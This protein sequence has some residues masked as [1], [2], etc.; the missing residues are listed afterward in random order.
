ME[1]RRIREI[2]ESVKSEKEKL[3]D[4]QYWLKFLQTSSYHYKHSFDDQIMINLQNPQF[5]A[6]SDARSWRS[7]SRE[8]QGHGVPTLHNGKIR[9]LFDI[10]QT[11]A[12]EGTPLPWVWEINDNQLNIDYSESVS[13]HLTEKYNLDSET[14]EEQLYDITLMRTAKYLNDDK[15]DLYK[16]VAESAAYSLLYRCCPGEAQPSPKNLTGLSKYPIEEIGQAVSE[17]SKS[18]FLEIESIVR[19]TRHNA[20]EEIRRNEHNETRENDRRS[21]TRSEPQDRGISSGYGN[22][23]GMDV[24]SGR[25]EFPVL[26]DLSEGSPYRSDIGSGKERISGDGSGIGKTIGGGKRDS[27]IHGSGVRHSTGRNERELLQDGIGV[28]ETDSGGTS[29][30]DPS[31]EVRNNAQ[32]LSSQSGSQGI[33]MAEKQ[34]ST[35]QTSDSRQSS[36]TRN[37]RYDS[38]KTQGEQSGIQRSGESGRLPENSTASEQF[39]ENSR[40]RNSDRTDI[41]IIGNTPYRYIPQKT[42]RKY[43]T[44]IAAKIADKLGESGIKFSGK[45]AGETTTITVSKADIERLEEIAHSFTA[46]KEKFAIGELKITQDDIEILR[47][48]EPRKSILNFTAEE[49]KLTE[50]WQQRFE[51]DIHEKSPY[52]RALNGDWRENDESKVTVIQVEDRNVDFKTVSDDIKTQVIQRGNVINND[53][54]WT[55]QVSRRGLEDSLTYA[56]RHNNESVYNMLYNI[57]DI[58]QNGTLLDSVISEKNNNNK[59]NNTAFMHKMYSVCKFNNEPY[60][61]K[62]A[63]EEFAV[64]S[65]TLKRLYN[66]QD[67]KIEPLRHAA[68]ADLNQLALSV[69]NGTEISIADLFKIVKASDKDFYINKRTDIEK[70]KFA[71]DELSKSVAENPMDRAIRLI[72]EY[73]EKE[74]GSPG[75]FSNMDHIELA[76]KPDEETGLAGIEAY[77]DLET[78][79]IVKE[80]DGR[81]VDEQLFN[82]L[83]HMNTVLKN[84][85]F[86]KLIELS[87]N[88]KSE[89]KT[90][91]F[92]NTEKKSPDVSE[93]SVG[94]VILYDG[95]RREVEQISENS[96][97]L[98]DLDAPDFGGILLGTSDVLA[99]NGWQQDMNEKGFEILSKAAPQITSKDH[100]YVPS[101]LSLFGEPVVYE[102]DAEEK[103]IYA[104]LMRGSGFQDGKFRIEKFCK[105]NHSIN[106]FAK[107]LKDEYGTGGRSGNEFYA[108]ENYDSKGIEIILNR[109]YDNEEGKKIHLKWKEVAE[110]ISELVSKGEYIAKADIDDHI[111]HAKYTLKHY[112]S[113]KYYNSDSESD[114]IHMERAKNILKEYGILSENNESNKVIPESEIT[115]TKPDNN[116]DLKNNIEESDEKNPEEN[117]KPDVPQKITVGDRFRHKITGNIS[118]V[119]SLTG[120]FPWITDECTVTRDSGAFSVTE[121][122]SYN[123][124]LNSDLYEYIDHADR[125]VEQAKT[126]MKSDMKIEN[127]KITGDFII[128][129]G[130]KSKFKA[131][132]KAIRTLKMIEKENRPATPEEQVIL[133]RYVGWG[134]LSAAFDSKNAQWSAEYSELKSLLTDEEYNAAR[135]SVLDSFYT[136]PFIIESIYSA[137][138]NMG[139]HGGSV[140]DPS[141]GTGNFLG[142]MPGSMS[143]NSRIY[144]VEKDSV[145]GRIAKFLYPDADIQITGFEKRDFSDNFFDVAVGNI[146]F[147]SFKISDRRYDKYNF[148]VHDYFIAKTLDKVRPGGVIAFITSSGTLDKANPSVRKYISQRAELLGAVRLPN[149]AFKSYAGTEVTSDIIFLRKREKMIDIA[150]DWVYTSKNP[151]GLTINNYFIENPEMILGKVVEGNKLYGKGT[152]VVPFENS[153]LK[154]ILNEAVKKIKGNYTAEKSVI[155]KPSGKKKDKFKPEILPAD[156]TVKNFSYAEIDGKIF[157]REN[158][159]MTEMPFTGKRYERVSGIAAISKCVREL[160]NMQLEGY[161]DEAIISKRTELNQLYDDFTKKNGLL[162]DK[163]NRDIFREDVSLPLVLSLEKVK[164]GKLIGKADIF[165]K[166]TLQPPVRITHADTAA[167]ALAVSISEK[168]GVDLDFMSE[169]MDGKEKSEIISDL[170]G[171]IFLNPETSAWETADAYLSGNI[172]NKL[173]AAKS[174]AESNP[175]FTENVSALEAAM[176]DRIEAGDITAKLGSPWID[177]KYIQEFMYELFE[178]P[179]FS[180]NLGIDNNYIGI[181]HNPATAKWNVMNKSLDKDNI[182]SNTAYGT[183]RKSGYS[184]FEDS[185]NMI[186]TTVYDPVYNPEKDKTEYVINHDETLLARQKQELIENAFREWIFKDPERREYL[187]EKYNVLYNSIRPREY[188]GSHL[189]FAGMNPEITLKKHQKDAVAH[190]LYGGNTL[191]AH[192]VGAGKTY[193]MIAAAMEGKR[194]GLH[195]KSLLAVPNHMTEQFANDFLTLYPNANILIAHEDDFKKENRQKLCAKIATGEFDAIIIGHSQL[196]KIPVSKER[197]EQFIQDQINELINDIAEMKE[198]NAESFTVKDMERTKRDYEAK[199][200]KLIEKPIKDDVV[201][202]EEMGIDKL[203]IDEADMFKNLSVSTKMRNISGVAANRKVQKTQDLYIKCQYLDELTGGKGIVFATGTPVSNSITELFIMQKYLQADYLR[204]SGLTHFD[205][206]A[207]NF[208][209]KVTKLEYAPTGKGFRQKTRLS[210]F[211]NLPELMTAFKECADIKTAE[212]LNL[213]EPECE[214][215]IIAAEPTETQKNLIQ[216]LSERAEKI[217]NKQ[218]TPDVDNMLKVT[219]DGIKIGLDQRLINPLLPDEPNTKINMCVNNVTDIWKKTAGERLTHVIFCDYSTPKKDAFNLY[220]DVKSKLIANGI[221]E[222]EIAFIHDYEKPQDKERLFDKVRNGE[223]RIVLGSTQKMGAGTNIQN[224]LYAM[225]H[226][227]APWKPR[228]MEQRL[229]R[230]KRQGNMNDKVHEYIYVTKDTFDAYRFQ[231][232]ET[233]QGFISQ[234]MT[235]KNPVR[236]CED[237]SQSEMEFAEVKA[238]CA[239]NPLIREKMEIDIEV[240]KLQTLKSAYLNQRYKLEDNVL[241]HIP[242]SIA[243]AKENL[244]AVLADSKITVQNPLKRDGEG[245]VIF[246]GM[247]I[248]DHV[249]ADKKEA[250]TALI[251]AAAKALTGNPN[252]RTEIGQY[253]GFRLDVFFDALSNDIKMDIKGN[254]SYRIT[255]SSSDTGNLTRIDNAINHIPE[256]IDEYKS[257]IEAL[258][259]QLENSKAELAKPFLKEQELKTKLARQ[260]ELDR[261][262]NLDNKENLLG[263][264]NV[265]SFEL[266]TE[267]DR[268]KLNSYNSTQTKDIKSY[269]LEL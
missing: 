85:D 62:L 90:T 51:T 60:L 108:F 150:P 129:G 148:A 262:L 231:T 78:F 88:D 186:D 5:T 214:R 8:P 76:Y 175:D 252:A 112:N 122:I 123:Q 171:V 31:R 155:A 38:G 216:S 32:E 2:K 237:V 213:P 125:T 258:N 73:C 10:T 187:V 53:T 249:Y 245:N 97:S 156:P 104:A 264:D 177:D 210:K 238:L 128:E 184:I 69:L 172:R 149:N 9:Y 80:Q 240:H 101:Q 23:K 77:A 58:I 190:A 79:R 179:K 105:E 244:N 159:I 241:K 134:G 233:K 176:P 197:E 110:R 165:T 224:K 81:V 234:I 133:S 268:Q 207:A 114:K 199:L 40:G 189:T 42:Y 183:S 243:K 92:E 95:K 1:F 12:P 71:N 217:H 215:H 185:L 144:A 153:D 63:V 236:V 11:S 21:E 261:Q 75:N 173:A 152:M 263:K 7:L 70:E 229:G 46:E 103:A 20:I 257:E 188:D 48:I 198:Q 174:A 195:N 158:S 13:K 106:E 170:K 120:A 205:A 239:G 89:I 141:T 86:D 22:L 47:S 162:N 140:L 24:R 102:S 14:L 143:D 115:F 67:I 259:T 242:E 137:L 161:S 196:I 139:F 132:S 30:G 19:S 130:A 116:S 44:D 74:F 87:D 209:Q 121:N 145:S 119:V 265:K 256:K 219:T 33:Y 267:A 57:N 201:T 220:D 147:G 49:I 228:D 15:S 98:K 218:V 107:M 27:G 135:A 232:L 206:W 221:P 99:Y 37:G 94:D 26:S 253:R 246:F 66:V 227:D 131:N 191:F 118:E 266:E 124:L 151:D 29:S 83:D 18:I 194:L 45:I 212:D 181:Q 39:S 6:C 200:K 3:S 226:L 113:E 117:N 17:I 235:S 142:K 225:H 68:F 192:K 56:R 157:Y 61:A 168:A 138:E 55:I 111:Y 202:F 247:T 93:L 260:S 52:Y 208:A 204:E 269:D 254:G 91:V 100:Q 4:T 34:R 222:N 154:V 182:K 203:F 65:D 166:R 127:F 160:L 82:S 193:E 54:L 64:Q 230:M 25:G 96:I 255:L 28:L 146:P 43:D 41:Q 248:N 180:R 167:D 178:T 84:L 136:P 251:E 109:K 223:I 50:T 59:A 164:D 36:G 211:S 126:S 163:T 16:V 250:G 72:N 169:L 35:E